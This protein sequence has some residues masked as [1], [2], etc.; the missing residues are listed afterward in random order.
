MSWARLLF[1]SSNAKTREDNVLDLYVFG[2]FTAVFILVVT[3]DFEYTDGFRNSRAGLI[4]KWEL[5]CRIGLWNSYQPLRQLWN[6]KSVHSAKCSLFDGL[7]A[8]F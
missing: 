3:P 6:G 1:G 7:P 2:G 4:I 5:S 8:N